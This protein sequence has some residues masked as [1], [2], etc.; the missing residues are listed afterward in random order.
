MDKRTM[1]PLFFVMIAFFMGSP[2]IA[3]LSENESTKKLGMWGTVFGFLLFMVW[4]MITENEGLRRRD[5]KFASIS[6][7]LG[8]PRGF[9]EGLKTEGWEVYNPNKQN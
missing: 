2:V 3:F 4:E 1:W 9:Q 5:E 6:R 8:N 7:A